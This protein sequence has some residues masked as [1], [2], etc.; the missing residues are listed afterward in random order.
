MRIGIDYTSAV[1]Q[2]AGI[3][4]YTRGLIGAL[5]EL[6]HETRYVLF[7]AGRDPSRRAWPANYALR[8]LPFSDRHLAILWQ[9]LQL[10][11]PV[12]TF[13]GRL[14]LYHSP[15]F[16]LPPVWRART[17]LTVHDLSF[18]RYPACFSRPLLDY[19]MRKVPPA[20]ERADAILADSES[21]RHDLIELLHMAADRVTVVYPA[22]EPHFR[23]DEDESA[24]ATT[25]ARYGI[26]R[27]Y[28]LGVG[29]LQPRKNFGLLIRAYHALR[30]SRGIP[31]RLVIAGGQ[32]WLFDEI[33]DTIR[34]L[35]L[36][37]QVHLTG[38]V[39][40]E[41]LPALYRGAALFAFPSLYE[42]F[43]IPVLEAMAC[44]VPVVTSA[45]SSLPEAAGDAALLVDPNDVDALTEALWRVLDDSALR[46][47]LR[48]R[49]FEQIKRFSWA[50]SAR[51]LRAIYHAVGNGG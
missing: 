24:L 17:I 3:G 12:E 45:A 37:E 41:D 40:D 15:D 26:Q 8:A 29:T 21:T 28:L 6:D 14:D 1:R 47:A 7:S 10:P 33:H 44:G 18:M 27:P 42:G 22:V 43:G 36:G 4:R 34:S 38:F 2:Q 35:H 13:T 39:A 23:P 20:V 5:A 19:L 30:A 31:H 32:G 25:L 51:R 50:E 46:N 49:G 9:R 16:V 11:L 48:A